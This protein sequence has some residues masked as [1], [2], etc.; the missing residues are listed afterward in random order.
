VIG[1]VVALYY[2]MDG[3]AKHIKLVYGIIAIWSIEVSAAQQDLKPSNS[4]T[5]CFPS[6]PTSLSKRWKSNDLGR[7]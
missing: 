2:H 3:Y 5:A 4:I 6:L 7:D 1:M